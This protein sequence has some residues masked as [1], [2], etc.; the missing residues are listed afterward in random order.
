MRT[1]RRGGGIELADNRVVAVQTPRFL[2]TFALGFRPRELIADR[3]API[4]PV[5][6]QTGKYRIF[7]KD[8][9]FEYE[10]LWA[11]GTIPNEIE[12]EMSSDTYFAL[13]R[14]LRT[15]LLDTVERAQDADVRL[16]QRKT[17]LVT[18]AIAIGRE[19]RVAR[20]LTTSTNY[21]ASHI[22]T[23]GGGAEWN[24]VPASVLTDLRAS[25]AKVEDDAQ[26]D[27]GELTVVI[28]TQVWRGAVES[29]TNILD[30]IKY[31]E[32]GVVTRELLATLLGVR[33]V[34][35]GRSAVTAGGPKAGTDIVT[36]YTTTY[37]WGDTVWVGLADPDAGDDEEVP[38]F[39]RSFN[40]REETGGQQIQIRQ[41]R[42]MDEGAET[43]WIEAKQAMDEK[44]TYKDAGAI[45]VNTLS[46][47]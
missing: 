21:S 25:I 46:T 8:Q 17:R 5:E 42:H 43:D 15:R 20:L 2:Q 37:L 12:A 36:G 26:V 3:L 4:I 39:A 34:I 19:A 22:T 11:P 40:W 24:T 38:A 6:D 41:Y 16:R 45:I 28:P 14:K 7:G 32:R 44:I 27:A 30:L 13:I 33:D 18:N 29:N 1:R 23:K 31:S 9:F 10:G 47:I 35:I